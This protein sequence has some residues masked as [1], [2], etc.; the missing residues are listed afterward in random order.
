MG[1][2]NCVNDGSVAADRYWLPAT[3][4]WTSH[5]AGCLQRT[6]NMGSATFYHT[7]VQVGNVITNAG[8]TGN[9]DSG[10]P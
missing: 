9:A 2:G 7:A 4:G 3:S 5:P 6:L 10:E 8:T 1:V